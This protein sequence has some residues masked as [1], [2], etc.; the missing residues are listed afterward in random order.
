[1]ALVTVAEP[2]SGGTQQ[3]AGQPG[4]NAGMLEFK[5]PTLC[6]LDPM[7]QRSEYSCG[8]TFCPGWEASI[9]AHPQ[10][11]EAAKPTI[12]GMSKSDRLTAEH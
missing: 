7:S 11:E 6:R 12:I 1:M 9:H 3:P 10:L 5:A 2:P 8:V 4:S